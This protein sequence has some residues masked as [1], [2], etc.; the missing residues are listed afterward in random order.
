[1]V[2]RYKSLTFALAGNPN[3][4]KTSLFNQLT[5]AHQRVANWSGV[6]VD[7]KQGLVKHKGHKI[8]MVD[9]PG[10]YSL[11]TYSM[12]ETVARDYV[13]KEKPDVVV[14]VLDSTNLE[15]NLY[16]TVQLMEMKV[17]LLLVLNM[18]DEAAKKDIQIDTDLLS[19]FFGAPIVKTIGRTGKGV[20]NLLEKGVGICNGQRDT[21]QPVQV[22]YAGDLETEIALL[23]GK[24]SENP[25]WESFNSRWVAI[26]LLENDKSIADFF[27][28]SENGRKLLEQMG[29]SRARIQQMLGDD[30]ELLIAEARYGFIR[31]AMR[32][33]VR[34]KPQDRKTI[35][36]KID[37]VLTH[38][39]LAFPIFIFFMWLLFQ[40]T[41][42]LGQYPMN[43]IESGMTLLGSWVGSVLPMGDLRSL[44]VDGIIA[45]V[46]GLLIFLPNIVILFL[47]LALMEDTGYLA[48]TAFIMDKVMHLM[49]LH[50]K[51]FI[52]M[53][54]GFGCNVPA[55]MAARTL[56]SRSDRA[57]TILVAPLMSCSARLTVYVLLAGAFFP[58]N[59]GN[60]IFSL[61][62]LGIIIAFVLGRLFRRVFFKGQSYPFVMELPPYRIPTGRSVIIHMWDKAV[63]HYLK[64]MGGAV[65]IFSII[66]WFLGAFPRGEEIKTKYESRISTVQQS[67]ALTI[68]EKENAVM[69]LRGQMQ[70]EVVKQTYIGKLG[71]FILP[72]IE[73]L[74]FE[75]RGGV[76]LLTGFVAKEIVV[77]SMGVLFGVGQEVDENNEGLRDKLKDA[78]TP[79]SAYA[80]LVFV[81][82]Y[83]PCLVTLIT[84]FRELRAWKLSVFS[85]VYQVTLAWCFAFA[86]YQGGKMLGFT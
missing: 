38:K 2:E 81:L 54:M 83:T 36:D 47:G 33:A 62:A 51:S 67:Q 85:L 17:N 12:D 18:S 44:I 32:E 57:V 35:T 74:G 73:P 78:F 13:M 61:Y 34:E 24:I 15:R 65:L 60:V 26:K 4:G 3:S 23:Q 40:A 49:G 59:A 68:G 22:K 72:V 8:N 11:T 1:M 80:F 14:D 6:T 55:I 29:E 7:I 86:V 25:E 79:L 53:I 70:S 42:T 37:G 27:E 76:A 10:T 71:H 5:G 16:L 41:F 45:G 63:K 48:R 64:K 20:K 28:N 9:L 43:W 58:E 56:E 75:W 31:G 50:G 66:L 21:F 69:V 19:K 84:T 77:S 82:L 52:P 30:P 39:Y 46:G